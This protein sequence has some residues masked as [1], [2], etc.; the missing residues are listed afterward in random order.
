VWQQFL[1]HK[2]LPQVAIKE[3]L[4]VPACKNAI[5]PLENSSKELGIFK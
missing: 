1:P 5:A 4:T 2:K 3:L